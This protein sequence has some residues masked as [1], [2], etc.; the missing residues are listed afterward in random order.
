MR[1]TR[2][3]ADEPTAER[4]LYRAD[5]SSVGLQRPIDS[6]RVSGQRAVLARYPNVKTVEQLGAMQIKALHWVPQVSVV[7][8]LGL[9]L[10]LISPPDQGAPMGPTGDGHHVPLYTLC[11]EDRTPEYP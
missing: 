10:I 9:A 1:S 11:F 5:L 2:A 6:L 8:F 3:C 7:N 4:N